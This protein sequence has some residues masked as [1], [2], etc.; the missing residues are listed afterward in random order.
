MPITVFVQ[1]ISTLRLNEP[2]YDKN[3]INDDI[4]YMDVCIC[5]SLYDIYMCSMNYNNQNEFNT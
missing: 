4:K 3:E 1:I 2:Y 5:V